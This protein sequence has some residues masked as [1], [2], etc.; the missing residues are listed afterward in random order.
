MILPHMCV[1][2]K[3]ILFWIETCEKHEVGQVRSALFFSNTNAISVD[4]FLFLLY[5]LIHPRF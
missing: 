1:D 2:I 4:E 3:I 5:I